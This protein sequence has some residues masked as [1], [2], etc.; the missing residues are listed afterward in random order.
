MILKITIF[1]ILT[2]A[3]F[4]R[5]EGKK[6]NRKIKNFHSNFNATLAD[7]TK[8]RNLR[9]ARTHCHILTCICS[10][11]IAKTPAWWKL[12]SCYLRESHKKEIIK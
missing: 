5:G 2:I 6:S 11:V 3:I 12:M 7:Y 8:F 4:H 9:S 1:A 10:N